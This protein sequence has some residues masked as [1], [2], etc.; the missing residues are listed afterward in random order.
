[1]ISSATQTMICPTCGCSLVR[2]G[3]DKERASRREFKAK[4]YFFCCEGCASLFDEDPVSVLE[5]TCRLVVCPSCLAEK[6]P[7]HTVEIRYSGERVSFCRCPHCV[8]VF[9][10]NPY[11]FLER[12]AGQTEFLGIFSSGQGCCDENEPR[13]AEDGGPA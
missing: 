8:V 6:I 2:L 1:M 7:E 5:E 11:Y 4:E 9:L 13:G 12:L 3:I 10:E